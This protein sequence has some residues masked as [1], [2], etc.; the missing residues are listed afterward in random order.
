MRDEVGK[1]ASFT[2]RVDVINHNAETADEAPEL[3]TKHVDAPQLK[4][5]KGGRGERPR[6]RARI[7]WYVISM[8]VMCLIADRVCR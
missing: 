3:L 6:W 7:K 4:N 2:R 1:V 8:R 5:R